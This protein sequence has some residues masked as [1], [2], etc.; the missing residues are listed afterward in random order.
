NWKLNNEVDEA[1]LKE[2]FPNFNDYVQF[3]IDLINYY[4]A[5]KT[6]FIRIKRIIPKEKDHKH[7]DEIQEWKEK[8]FQGPKTGAKFAFNKL[9]HFYQKL[10]KFCKKCN[11]YLYDEQDF[12]SESETTI[13]SSITIIS[14][15]SPE[16]SK[17]ILA[18]IQQ[19]GIFDHVIEKYSQIDNN[20]KEVLF[21][22]ENKYHEFL[23]VVSISK[24]KQ[25]L[26]SYRNNLS[27]DY[28]NYYHVPT[29]HKEQSENFEKYAIREAKEETD[30]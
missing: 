19:K 10:E 9:E 3:V 6:I 29:G 13:L 22:Y 5:R 11:H 24:D 28:F 2:A 26:I 30:L 14:N 8:V 20:Q 23:L 27:K 12:K 18:Q 16:Q 7:F 25:V 15:N 17:E 1:V 4:K 21:K